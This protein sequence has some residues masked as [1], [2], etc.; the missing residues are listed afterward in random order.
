VIFDRPLSIGFGEAN[1]SVFSE[2]FSKNNR[3]G[4]NK[5]GEKFKNHLL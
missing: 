2:T 1:L 5:T 4:D 3:G